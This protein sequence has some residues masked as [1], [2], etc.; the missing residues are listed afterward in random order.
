MFIILRA[1]DEKMSVARKHF[2]RGSSGGQ[3]PDGF[4]GGG[5]D[6]RRPSLVRQR[7]SHAG[8][9]VVTIRHWFGEMIGFHLEARRQLASKM[10]GQIV[11]VRGLSARLKNIG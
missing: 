6:R 1:L 10:P 8:Q 2:R 11:I 4:I 3:E 5:G 9:G 7:M